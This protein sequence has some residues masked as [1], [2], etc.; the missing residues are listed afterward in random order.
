MTPP[1]RTEMKAR[2]QAFVAHLEG[3][4]EARG[5]SLSAAELFALVGA[6]QD[7]RIRQMLESRGALEITFEDEHHGSF[8]NH[9][10]ALVIP[11]GPVRVH[12]PAQITGRLVMRGA[13]VTLDFDQAHTLVARIMVMEVKVKGVEVSPHH[14]AVRVP[15]GA[16]DQEY[17]F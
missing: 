8:S 15:G 1:T 2:A 3:V 9:G 12:V 6:P 5:G 10:P 13:E 14:M 11:V 16:F 17:R 7:P 4:R